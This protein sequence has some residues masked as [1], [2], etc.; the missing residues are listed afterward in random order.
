MKVDVYRAKKSPGNHENLYIFVPA[1]SK[2][3]DLP[4]EILEKTGGLSIEKTIDIQS[5]EK[6]I[7]LNSDEALQNL[8]EHGYHEQSSKIEFEI[9][10]GGHK[11]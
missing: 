10:V 6:R 7:A 8:A 4:P 1:G 2:V 11:V 3:D 9:R 5:G